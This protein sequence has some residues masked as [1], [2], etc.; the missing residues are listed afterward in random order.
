M[1]PNGFNSPDEVRES[2]NQ[3]IQSFKSCVE[4]AQYF[5]FTLGLTESWF[6]KGGE[7][8][9]PICPGAIAGEFDTSLHKFVNQD[10]NQVYSHL[11]DAMILMKEVNP[12]LKFLLTVSPVPLTATNFRNHVAVATMASK[13]VLRAV[14]E[15][16]T[17]D[18]DDVDY[19][20]SYEIINSPV[21]KGAFFEPN[22]RGVNPHGVR[23]VMDNYFNCLVDK[24]GQYKNDGQSS[25][26]VRRRET[27]TICEEELLEAFGK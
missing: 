6:N 7:Y 4:Q 1:E 27:D 16:L 8:E 11:A 20:P 12:Q 22:Q 24:Y 21:F 10:F 25:T 2:L 18:H 19:F 5:V 26:V 23:F 14:T 3:T 13:S 17:T 9:Y 15:K